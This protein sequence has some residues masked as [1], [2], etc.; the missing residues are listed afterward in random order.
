MKKKWVMI[1]SLLGIML[2]VGACSSVQNPAAAKEVLLEVTI[3]EFM[4]EK[5]I[6]RQVEVAR[7]GTLT[8]LLGSNP[9]TGFQWSE[10][11]EI[12]DRAVL[13]PGVH[14]Y[15]APEENGGTPLPGAAGKEEWT[16]YALDKG[17]TD[18]SMDYSRSWEGGEKDEWTFKLTVVVR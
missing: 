5:N 8:V 13:M 18:V 16:F 1:F 15:V 9:S 12:T 17:T 4:A 3:D 2:A 11:A 10:Q 6:S 14:R 7:G